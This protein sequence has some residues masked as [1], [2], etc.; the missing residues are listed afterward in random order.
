MF[1]LALEQV[2]PM[3]VELGIEVEEGSVIW[4]APQYK[5]KIGSLEG[6][7]KNLISIHMKDGNKRF[8]FLEKQNSVTRKKVEISVFDKLI[9]SSSSCYSLTHMEIFRSFKQTEMLPLLL[10]MCSYEASSTDISYV[11][12]AFFTSDLRF[13][14]LSF[15]PILLR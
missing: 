11:P 1:T 15:S 6:I 5:L 2:N 9:L 8:K 4:C 7:Q 10:P 14:I 12:S 3:E 13:I